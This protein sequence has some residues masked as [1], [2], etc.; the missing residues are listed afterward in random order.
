MK[1]LV[2]AAT[3]AAT[4]ALSLSL[5]KGASSRALSFSSLASLLLELSAGVREREGSNGRE[6]RRASRLSPL[7]R[8]VREQE[9]ERWSFSPFFLFAPPSV[10]EAELTRQ[11]LL[12][13]HHSSEESLLSLSLSLSHARNERELRASAFP[14]CEKTKSAH[15]DGDFASCP[16]RLACRRVLRRRSDCG[17]PRRRRHAAGPP[18]ADDYDQ[19][20]RRFRLVVLLPTPPGDAPDAPG[21]RR[22]TTRGRR[23]RLL[24]ASPQ[25]HAPRRAEHGAERR[26]R[27]CFSSGAVV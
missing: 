3:A 18:N 9:R 11:L 20:R 14:L 23:R 1:N 5:E 6:R 17:T 19:C 24:L 7:R 25:A 16:R 10:S 22:E 26:H 8:R 15:P 4:T 21:A 12:V 27:I 2:A 13:R